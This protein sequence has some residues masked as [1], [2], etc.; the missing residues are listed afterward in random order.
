M[1]L[2]HAAI[3]WK[4]GS[5][6]V[7]KA[8]FKSSLKQ[9]GTSL[10]RFVMGATLFC[11]F[12]AASVLISGCGET[13]RPVISAINPVGPAA[14]PQ[15]YAVVI[16][17][18]S[19]TS[20]GL[21]TIVDYSGDSILINAIL[22][23]NPYY[24]GFGTNNTEGFTLNSDGSVSSFGISTSL[25]SSQI[26]S[27][28][29]LPCTNTPCTTANLPS[30][31]VSTSAYQ[32]ITQ[33]GRAPA[34]GIAILHGAPTALVEEQA[35]GTNPSYTIAQSSAQRVYVLSAGSN[36][37]TAIETSTITTSNVIPTGSNPIYGMMS[38]DNNRSFVINN[39]SGTVTV[40]N[41]QQNLLDPNPALGANSTIPVGSLPIWADMYYSGNELLVANQGSNTTTDPASV[42]IINT[43]LCNTTSSTT[44]IPPTCNT[45]APTDSTQF[46]QIIAKVPLTYTVGG[47]TYNHVPSEIC[48]LQD[49]TK[50]Y[51][52][53][54]DPTQAN[55]SVS[56][57][58][59]TTDTV[60]ATIPVA[61]HP[62]TIAC[63]TGTPTGKVYVTAPDS[64]ILSII[65]SQTNTVPA[66]VDLQGNGVMVRTTAQ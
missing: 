29:L 53:N 9:H 2:H 45:T 43:S 7:L 11:A 57:I 36:T 25:L 35:T 17:S 23:Q 61:G 49:G 48:V 14:Q 24:L 39:G 38:A 33:P 3:Y 10:E 58:D 63:T 32:W 42:S 60:I 47:V 40:I 30:S 19:S 66:T 27:S 13:Y 4:M 15:K 52:A 8:I 18:P 26:L 62:T 20:N 44:T 21:L 46:G 55:G 22:G 54:T 56:S 16:S 37:A 5:S 65:Y 12:A 28:T 34:G 31:I 1:Y 50:A 51:V 41:S 59:L 6:L 64:N